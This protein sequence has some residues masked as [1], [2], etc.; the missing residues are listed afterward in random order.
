MELYILNLSYLSE[1]E[2]DRDDRFRPM[3]ALEIASEPKFVKIVRTREEALEHVEF[4]KKALYLEHRE[5]V[6]LE[7]EYDENEP[8]EIPDFEWKELNCVGPRN[9]TM[10]VGS[11]EGDVAVAI[12]IVETSI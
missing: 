4:L 7:H 2:A 11:M 1:L 5:D 6:L 3:E 12:T 8:K 10:F 9:R